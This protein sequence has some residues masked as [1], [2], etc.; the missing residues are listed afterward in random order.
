MLCFN[1][2][3]KGTSNRTI[4]VIGSGFWTVFTSYFLDSLVVIV[5]GNIVITML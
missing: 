1:I 3:G 5:Q 2:D 4:K